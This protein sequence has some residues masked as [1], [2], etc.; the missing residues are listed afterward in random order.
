MPLLVE[1]PSCG[2]KLK[3]PD[4]LVGKQVRCADCAGTFTAENRSAAPPPPSRAPARRE[5]PDDLDEPDDRPERRSRRRDP[6]NYAPDRGGLILAFG[7][8]SLVLAITGG[9]FFVGLPLGIMAW[10]WGSKDQKEIAAGRMN[11]SGQGNTQIGFILGIIGTILNVL[12]LVGVCIYLVF[13]VIIF[14]LFAGLMAGAAGSMTAPMPAPP[15]KKPAKFMLQV[16]AMPLRVA[17]YLPGRQR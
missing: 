2:K 15:Q 8:I 17:D 9:L 6:G 7:I 14:G 4:N 10:I 1:C 13:V 11:P 3:I 5:A 16:G 12:I